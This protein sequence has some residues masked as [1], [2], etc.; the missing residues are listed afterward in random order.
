VLR[1]IKGSYE[2]NDISIGS[3]P[4]DSCAPWPVHC[5]FS[6]GSAYVFVL[7][8]LPAEGKVALRYGG[9]LLDIKRTE[10]IEAEL[11]RARAF[12]AA[13]LART[14]KEKPETHSRAVALDRRLAKASK[15]WPG[16][17]PTKRKVP[18]AGTGQ[19]P[20]DDTGLLRLEGLREDMVSYKE[21]EDFKAAKRALVRELRTTDLE[22]MEVALAMN[23]LS[24][25]RDAWPKKLLWENALRDLTGERRGDL[26]KYNRARVRE[27]LGRAGIGKKHIDEYLATVPKGDLDGPPAFP[28]C[29]PYPFHERKSDARTTEFILHYHCF[30]RGEMFVSY[31]MQFEVLGTLDPERV[32]TII[33]AMYGSVDRQ[34]H[35]VAYRAIERM[36]GTAF[37]GFVL[38]ELLDDDPHA[39]RCL[40]HPKDNSQTEQ[41][42]RELIQSGRTDLP[43][44]RLA[45]LW[46][47][48]ERGLCFEQVAIDEAI[49]RLASLEE[50]G[51]PE[52]A[53]EE[54]QEDAA[55]LREALHHYLAAAM[56]SREKD[57]E[58]QPSAAEYRSWFKTHPVDEEDEER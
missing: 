46:Y 16:L 30:D 57:S 37:V 20:A 35:L 45:H 2:A 5:G 38:D 55:R 44:W 14:R 15:D 26:V 34:L 25:D 4:I 13:Y 54:K 52:G 43:E 27:E 22:T 8:S 48:L 32:K 41:R 1:V 49:S 31:G 50:K 9:S 18:A 21:G 36:P 56:R 33:P 51:K 17:T 11:G 23:W 42:L 12:K 40:V 19:T 47:R 53:R 6:K 24:D 10:A 28:F 29:A 7:P 3:G 58:K 39:W